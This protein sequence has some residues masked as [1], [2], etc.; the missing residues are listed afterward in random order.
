MILRT[1]IIAKIFWKITYKKSDIESTTFEKKS[2]YN[3][4]YSLDF[5]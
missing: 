3:I 1:G 4:L 2:E 5:D